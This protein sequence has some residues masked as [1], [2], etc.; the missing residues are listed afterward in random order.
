M[1]LKSLCDAKLSHVYVSALVQPREG[2]RIW[3]MHLVKDQEGLGI[4]IMGG[5]G[6]KRSPHGII[7]AHVEEGGATQ[8]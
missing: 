4:Q 6:S 8:R 3:K 5:R 2:S 1:I 7:V